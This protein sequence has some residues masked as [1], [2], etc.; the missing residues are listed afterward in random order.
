MADGE[1][2]VAVGMKQT[3]LFPPPAA[4]LTA[5]SRNAG[6]PFAPGG[7]FRIPEKANTCLDLTGIFSAY[8]LYG[9]GRRAADST[10]MG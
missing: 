1:S 8:E 9:S 6:S 3:R 5:Y 4:R 10:D 2:P 7:R